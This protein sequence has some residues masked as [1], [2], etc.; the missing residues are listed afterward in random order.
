[1]NAQVCMLVYVLNC[2]V[3]CLKQKKLL[4]IPIVFCHHMSD[5]EWGGIVVIS[6]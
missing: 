5:F 6:L 2:L 4:L 3:A 1:M